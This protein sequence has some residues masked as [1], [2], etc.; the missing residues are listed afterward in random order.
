M[1]LEI[2]NLVQ[3]YKYLGILLNEHLK[4][5]S[6]DHVFAKISPEYNII[7]IHLFE[8]IIIQFFLVFQMI[9]IDL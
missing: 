9:A 6:C 5:D 4:F 3:Q 7:I 8:I 2:I 1:G